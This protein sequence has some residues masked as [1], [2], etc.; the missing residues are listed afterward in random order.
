[1][2]VRL[3]QLLGKSPYRLVQEMMSTTNKVTFLIPR[4]FD[5]L[6]AEDIKK[7]LKTSNE[8]SKK[9]G[10]IDEIKVEIRLLVS[11][12]LFF[13]FPKRDFMELIYSMDSISDRAETL[14]KLFTLRSLAFPDALETS[15]QAMLKTVQTLREYLSNVLLDELDGLVNSSF[16]GPEARAVGA[17]IDGICSKAHELELEA[18]AAMVVVFQPESGLE[19]TEVILWSRI[20][21][22]LES[23]GLA[24]EKTATTLRSLMEK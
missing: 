18:H 1:M 3:D 16:S 11:Q 19:P 6:K 22:K 14:A 21:D 5:A 15:L 7:C 9:E 2:G 4:L 20:I 13:P 17:M 8:I 10:E 12:S 23:V 24:F